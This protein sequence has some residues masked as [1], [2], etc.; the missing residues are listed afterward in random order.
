MNGLFFGT[1]KDV[2]VCS[3]CL[4][5]TDFRSA[6]FT[7]CAL[8][9]NVNSLCEAWVAESVWVF[10]ISVRVITSSC[11]ELV[12]DLPEWALFYLIFFLYYVTV[13]F[14][15][16]SWAISVKVMKY[17]EVHELQASWAHRAS[18]PQR[19]PVLFIS[20]PS[21]ALVLS[22]YLL[23]LCVSLC[24]WTLF[25]FSLASP[26]VLCTVSLKWFLF[27]SWLQFLSSSVCLFLCSDRK[28][29]V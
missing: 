23:L 21:S 29:V 4:K 18:T 22:I 14:V 5:V 6:P 15:K 27:F 28:S 17:I 10:L 12:L 16:C 8:S 20:P 2:E 1:A 25:C 13:D 26:E 7:T 11:E 24:Y 3:L 19:F 9:E